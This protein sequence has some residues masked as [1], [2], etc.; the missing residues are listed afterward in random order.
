MFKWVDD[1]SLYL[2]DTQGFPWSRNDF[3]LETQKEVDMCACYWKTGKAKVV[4]TSSKP[5][6]F[7]DSGFICEHQG[8]YWQ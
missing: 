6:F 2:K 8:K 1:K 7:T 4:E 5:C 3:R